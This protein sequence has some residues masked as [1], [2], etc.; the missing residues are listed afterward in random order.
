MHTGNLPTMPKSTARRKKTRDRNEMP[1]SFLPEGN[2]PARIAYL[3]VW[4][5]LIP[6]AGLLLGL[7]AVFYG[8]LGY[9]WAKGDPKKRGLGHAFVS[10]VGGLFEVICNG[11]GLLLVYR[12]L[13]G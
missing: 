12:G 4:F 6:V 5:G 3:S 7:I 11:L 9:R 2:T 13:T 8:L 10:C 1:T